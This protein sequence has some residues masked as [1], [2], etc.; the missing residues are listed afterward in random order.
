MSKDQNTCVA[1]GAGISYVTGDGIPLFSDIQLSIHKGETVGLVGDNGVGKSTL[2]KILLKKNTST[3]GKIALTP[4]FGYFSQQK[5]HNQECVLDV[6]GIKLKKKY[7]ALNQV[8]AGSESMQVLSELDDDWSL[9]EDMKDCLLEVGLNIDLHAPLSSLSGGQQT[10]LRLASIFFRQE[11]HLIVLDEPSNHLD[12]ENKKWLKKKISATAAGVLLISHDRTLLN[13]CD[14]I[15]ELSN[16]GLRSFEGSFDQ[17]LENVQIEDAANL[18][19]Y[20][21]LKS[22]KK[23]LEKKLKQQHSQQQQ[24]EAKGKRAADKRGLDKITRKAKIQ[25]SQASEGSSRESLKNRIE[26]AQSK[27]SEAFA[28]VKQESDLVFDFDGAANHA[29]KVVIKIDNLSYGYGSSKLVFDSWTKNLTGNQ[30]VRLK[31]VNGSGKSTLVKI[32]IGALKPQAGFAEIMLPK[33]EVAV[34][35][36]YASFLKLE[37]SIL[38][39]F[40][41]FNPDFET[42]DIRNR[43]ALF[44]FTGEDVFKKI[45]DLSG[46]EKVRAALALALSAQTLPKLLILDEPTNNI[47]LKSRMQ[48]E[49]ILKKYPGAL[50]LVT[51]DDYFADAL[52]VEEEWEL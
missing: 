10:L 17:Y 9:A 4:Y 27:Q 6:F 39:N 48:L 29:A 20:E 1:S 37:S 26:A 32:L 30:R 5:E 36:Q 14:R 2:V 49:Y 38:E 7:L 42:S 3:S 31:G 11:N 24:R 50:L 19:N 40:T 47:D 8:L 51:H 22:Q 15:L 23:K 13:Q 52:G 34:I 35:D 33:K 43:L 41:E 28:S 18:R 46:G 16:L 21:F 44:H 12:T 45:G 25:Q